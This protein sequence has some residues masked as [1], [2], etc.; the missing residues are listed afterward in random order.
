MLSWGGRSLGPACVNAYVSAY[1]LKWGTFCTVVLHP[2]SS[3][4]PLIVCYV[5]KY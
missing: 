3:E 4:K 5:P 1:L 2:G